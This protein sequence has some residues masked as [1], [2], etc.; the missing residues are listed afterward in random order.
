MN[1]I[2][3]SPLFEARQV[4]DRFLDESRSL[5]V[6]RGYDDVASIHMDV[7]QTPG[8]F[9]VKA[10]ILGVSSEEVDISIIE[11]TLT[12]KTEPKTVEDSKDV[13]YLYRELR[14][15]P[16]TRTIKLPSLVNTDATEATFENGVLTVSI[17]K[18]EKAK[19]KQIKVNA[20]TVIESDS[21]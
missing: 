1:M 13:E 17:P 5:N 3:W 11:N 18:V 16:A 20:K 9:V 7:Y 21:K 10:G 14:T 2:R 4:V 12:I 8:A 15:G 6:I 19:P